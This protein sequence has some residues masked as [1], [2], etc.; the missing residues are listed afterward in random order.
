MGRTGMAMLSYRYYTGGCTSIGIAVG[1]NE[2]STETHRNAVKISSA[3]YTGVT[4]ATEFRL[5]YA[6]GK[7]FR[8]YGYAG[9]GI[10][11]LDER[12]DNGGRRKS[13]A[14]DFQFVP[15]GISIGERLAAFVELGVG[16]KGIL[17]GGLS[18][19][20]D[21][22]KTTLP[23]D[24]F[25]NKKA[26]VIHGTYDVADRWQYLGK[27]KSRGPKNDR[28]LSPEHQADRLAVTA[29]KDGANVI[30]LNRILKWPCNGCYRLTADAWRAP[31][32]DSLM[33]ALQYQEKADIG[34]SSYSYIVVYRTDVHPSYKD[35]TG[36]LHLD[37]SD[38]FEIRN[39]SKYI[40][41]ISREG[42][43]MLSVPGFKTSRFYIKVEKG[44]K[45]YYRGTVTLHSFKSKLSL[46]KVKERVGRIESN[47]HTTTYRISI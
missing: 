13:S 18:Y 4:L 25:D 34:D 14:F 10:S 40:F 30:M 20:F 6:N 46:K 1:M 39:N 41:K 36:Y 21:L 38:R 15:I 22:R 8:G 29:A 44:K 7:K 42:W 11:L 12:V 16:Y 27:I 32:A 33:L 45:Y 5:N 24:Q 31:E 19:R 9:G 28:D 17:T 23:T 26:A 43:V 3:K 47:N 2:F 35:K 37:S